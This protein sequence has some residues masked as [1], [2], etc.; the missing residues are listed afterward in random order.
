MLARNRTDIRQSL[1]SE[2]KVSL[3]ERALRAAQGER[4]GEPK[5]GAI[6]ARLQDIGRVFV[7]DAAG[8]VGGDIIEEDEWPVSSMVGS[9]VNVGAMGILGPQPREESMDLANTKVL[10][11][12][13]PGREKL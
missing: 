11:R 13:M 5:M 7:R 3:G 4:R 9:E 8:E 2:D 6:P 10:M 1:K 12:G